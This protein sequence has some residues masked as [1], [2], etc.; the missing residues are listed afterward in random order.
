MCVCVH[1]CMCVRVCA[2]VSICICVCQRMRCRNIK[3]KPFEDNVNVLDNEALLFKDPE[4]GHFTSPMCACKP[5]D[6]PHCLL[7]P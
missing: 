6:F 4:D 1:V 2:C 5:G 7:E 3:E